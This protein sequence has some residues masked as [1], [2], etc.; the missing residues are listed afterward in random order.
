MIKGLT[1]N[2]STVGKSMLTIL[3]L[4]AVVLSLRIGMQSLNIEIFPKGL[5]H[6]VRK[7]IYDH[8]IDRY[9]DKFEQVKSGETLERIGGLSRNLTFH[10]EWV[11]RTATPYALAM[12]IIVGYLYT[13][14]VTIGTIALAGV[15][16]SA[17]ITYFYGK[18]IVEMSASR[19]KS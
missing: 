19:E 3:C 15:L 11:I 18:R 12:L 17:G 1:E 13:R 5:F 14:S 2:A 16:G 4:W 7:E 9:S 8:I 6:H 10:M